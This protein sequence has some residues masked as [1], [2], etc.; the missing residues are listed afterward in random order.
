MPASQITFP[1][2]RTVS[3]LSSMALPPE[4]CPLGSYLKTSQGLSSVPTLSEE[5]VKMSAYFILS[6]PV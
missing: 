1:G 5:A 3:Q 4:N 6:F 2:Q